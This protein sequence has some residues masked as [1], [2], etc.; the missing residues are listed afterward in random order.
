MKLTNEQVVKMAKLAILASV[1]MGMGF[2]HHNPN[3]TEADL[4]DIKVKDGGLYIDYYQGRMVKFNATWNTNIGG[5]RDWTFGFENIEYQSWLHK[6]PSYDEL[7]KAAKD[8][9]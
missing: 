5:E 7:A 8:V 6:Y 2:L 3:L 1:P 4:T 9:G